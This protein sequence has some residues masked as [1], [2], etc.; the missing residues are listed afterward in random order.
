MT[1]HFSTTFNFIKNKTEKDT[2]FFIKNLYIF[3]KD[4]LQNI[5]QW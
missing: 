1:A 5:L 2:I 4:R 3:L